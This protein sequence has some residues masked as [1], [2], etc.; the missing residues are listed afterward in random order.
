MMRGM[1]LPPSDHEAI[2][3]EALASMDAARQIAPFSARYPGLTLDDAYRI[4][5]RVCALRTARGERVIG[6]KIGFTNRT[7]WA[8][9]GI[10]APVWGFVFDTTMR[11]LP[12]PH[13]AALHA[14]TLAAF[15]EPRIE[16]EIVFR[17]AAAPLIRRQIASPV[18]P[19]RRSTSA[20]SGREARS[21]FGADIHGFT[22]RTSATCAQTAATLSSSRTAVDGCSAPR[23]TAARRRLPCGS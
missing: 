9:Y 12:P 14:I 22:A 3:A 21:A 17:L 11:D 23:C 8:E 18:L 2:A 19:A 7:I 20:T 5:A 10:Y 4:S 6:R 15:A 1:T 13:Q 16:P